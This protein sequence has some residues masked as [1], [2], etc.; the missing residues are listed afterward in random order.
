MMA[1]GRA[2]VAAD[3]LAAAAA[4][5]FAGAAFGAVWGA[6]VVWDHPAE[7]AAAISKQMDKH[8]LMD[9]PDCRALPGRTGEGTRPY[10]VCGDCEI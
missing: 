8:F 3:G 4:G 2:G 9:A 1:V 5:F 6:G 7:H 10:V